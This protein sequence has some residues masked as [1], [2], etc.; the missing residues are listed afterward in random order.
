MRSYLHAARCLSV[1]GALAACLFI[2]G[3]GSNEY[4]P[5]PA[6]Q[7]PAADPTEDLSYKDLADTT[8]T[9]IDLSTG[10]D[11]EGS[12][13]EV[14]L[15][16]LV[17]NQDGAFLPS[18]NAY[19]FT[20]ELYPGTA[21]RVIPPEDIDLGITTSADRVV[22]LVMDSSGSMSGTT[23]TGQTR[24]QVAKEAA[25][26][27]VSL[28]RAGDRTS[29]VDFDD[30]ARIVRQLTDDQAALD[31]AIDT[32][33]ADG[34]TNLGAALTE[35]VRSVGTRPGKR[36]AILLT[37]GD[38]TVDSVAGG[39]DVWLNDSTS[40]RLQ[41][42]QLAR[43]N[44]LVVYTVGLGDGLSDTGL[45]DLQT[46]ATQ[47]GGTFFQAPTAEALLE[48]F[49]TTIPRELDALPPMQT[50]LLT[51]PN[52]VPLV[53]GDPTEVPVGVTVKYENGLRML[54]ATFDGS[55]TVE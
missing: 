27:F 13:D 22:A 47:T 5:G 55:Y 54:R 43:D 51:F 49:G 29:V 38:D 3:C 42:L 36:A 17:R 2:Q 23:D 40:S 16:A 37:D 44:G 33:T 19:N 12:S 48:A 6:E 9:S 31:K 41:G 18:F 20:V 8:N 21:P 53:P 30:S 32:F 15:Y 14:R 11:Y 35:A 26:L 10:L 45:A 34:A 1:A 52:S 7:A 24:I 28:M 25:K 39:P 50:Y 46:I 4:S